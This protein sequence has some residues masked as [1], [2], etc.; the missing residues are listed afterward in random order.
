MNSKDENPIINDWELNHAPR[1]SHYQN[2][3]SGEDCFIIGNGPSLNVT[4]LSKLEGKY[5][6]GLNKIYLIFETQKV[7]LSFVAAINELVIKQS[8]KQYCEMNFPVFLKQSAT[9]KYNIISPNIIQTKMSRHGFNFNM[10]MFGEFSEGYT[11]TYYA[12]QLAFAMGFK[13][14]F[15]VGVDHSFKQSGKPN[16]TQKME[17]DDPNHFHPDYF[18]GHE[19][20]LA[21]LEASELAYR[22]A[23]FYYQRS[24]RQVFDATIG[25]KLDVFPKMDFNKATK[26]CKNKNLEKKI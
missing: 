16:E 1:L 7:D 21:D 13:N 10:S 4:D 5:V 17:E 3:F 22:I 26:L 2:F 19:W 15:L 18:K 9:T 12:L 24:N 23:K 20:Q 25:G 8:A 11:V 14:V 6:F